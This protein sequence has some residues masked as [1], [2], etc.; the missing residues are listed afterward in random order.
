MTFHCVKSNMHKNKGKVLPLPFVNYTRKDK[1]K[2]Y[3]TKCDVFS[4]HTV[5]KTAVDTN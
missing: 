1:I 4:S 5:N 2:I 3:S